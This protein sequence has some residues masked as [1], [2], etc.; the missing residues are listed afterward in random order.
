MKINHPVTDV[1]KKFGID[2][3]ILSTTDLKGAITYIN[4]DFISIS[5]FEEEELLR[6]NH[7][8]VRHPDMP[9][10]AFESLWSTVQSGKPWMGLVKN[11]CKNGDYYW[12]DAMV[13]PIE[14][15]GKTVE[16]QSVRYKPEQASV[17]RAKPLYKRLLEGKAVPRS[18]RARI[19]LRNLLV[20][21]NLLSLLPAVL[22]SLVAA[23]QPYGLVGWLLSLGLVVLSNTLLMRP[24]AALVRRARSV[25]DNPLMSR[26]YTGRDDEFGQVL[27]AMRMRRSQLNGVIGR[28]SDTTRILRETAGVTAEAAQRTSQGVSTQQAE[29]EQAATAMTEMSATVQEVARNAALTAEQTEESRRES[30]AGQAVVEEVISAIHRLSD[31]IRESAGVIMELSSYSENIGNILA[32]IKGI[33]EQTNLLAL[34]AAIEAARAGEQGRGFAVVADE[35]RTLASRTQDSTQEIEKMIDSLQGGVKQAV[36]VM[37]RSQNSSANCVDIA[38]RA[39]DTLHSLGETISRISDMNLQVATAAEEQSAVAEDIQKS[40]VSISQVSEDTA[41]GASQSA[42]ATDEIVQSIIRLDALVDQFMDKR[43]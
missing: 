26:V 2:A 11:R 40:I 41:V 20:L 7:N 33:A 30:E 16:Y 10:A 38:A 32:V 12:V 17:E 43:V 8:V 14:R 27:T 39:G 23:L 29:I 5:G 3:N 1:E 9:P 4:P 13:T 35:V 36:Q 19:G 42:T 22:C 34:N 24:M 37:D 28:L 18:L 31:E 15:D 21:G 6:K 25:F